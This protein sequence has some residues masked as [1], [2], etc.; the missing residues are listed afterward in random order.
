MR[1]TD[2][3][4]QGATHTVDDAIG[5]LCSF[6]G[7]TRVL[8]AD[9]RM[10]PISEIEV[11]DEVLAYDPETGERGSRKVTHLWVHQDT[12]VELDI[13]GARVVT[14]EDHPF[15]SVT[16]QAWQ[17]AE[18]LDVG[19]EVLS[20]GGRT[21]VVGGLDVSTMVSGAAYN[22]TVDDIHTYFVE[23][24]LSEVLVHNTGC[25]YA[26]KVDSNT[27][28]LILSGPM[29]DPSVIRGMS[30]GD[31]VELQEMLEISIANRRADQ[32][33]GVFSSI[34][35]GHTARIADEERLLNQVN[36]LLGG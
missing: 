3:V 9:G 29:V 22:L 5:A 19:D 20:A 8:M 33:S 32:V 23:V 21:V 35:P 11:G 25:D 30:R 18:D 36:R 10:K 15:W 17:Q 1:G 34:D 7:E 27:G 28:S 13:G 12:L 6:S 16:D 26:L 24:G 14:T 2:D 31:L 4:A